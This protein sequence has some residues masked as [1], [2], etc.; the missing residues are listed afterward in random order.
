MTGR[1]KV[2]AAFSGEGADEMGVVICYE[3][4]YV[5][6]HWNQLTGAPWWHREV[7]DMDAQLAWH[8]EVVEKTGMDWFHL[9]RFFTREARGEVSIEE[10]SDGVYRVDRGT[11]AETKLVEPQIGGWGGSGLHSVHPERLVDTVEEIDARIPDPPG[12]SPEGV[13]MDGSGDLAQR[14]LAE[15]GDELYPMLHV[16]SPLWNC[17]HLWGFEGMMTMVAARP[18]LVEHVGRRALNR[19]LWNVREAAALGAAGIWIEE[20][21][22]D[23]V[24]PEAFAR[25]NVPYMKE[26]VDGIR[27]AGMHSIYYYCGDPQGKWDLLLEVGA[28]ALSLEE[29]KKGFD[30]DIEDVV[31][32]VQ[33][34]CAVL[35]N[36]DAVGVLQD[37]SEEELRAEIARQ[38]GAGRRN[39]NRFAISIG[40][41]VTPDTS[42]EKVKLYYDLARELGKK[43]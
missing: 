30:I 20:C 18:D 37:G 41:P 35:G 11:G 2:K 33:G 16:S 7:P 28:D 34:R 8:R 32:R 40:S 39:Q 24:S 38:M 12:A 14:M 9:P 4:I 1:E 5:R 31:E 6:D 19:Q 27:A 42:V 43:G 13:K 36:L 17:Y 15:F 23:M 25:L 22:T 3:G 29:S 10:R 21:L 26:L